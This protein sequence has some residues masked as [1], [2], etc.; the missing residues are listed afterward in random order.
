MKYG[1]N[2]LLWTDT[3]DESSF[4][5][6]E[7]LKEFGYDAVE[8]P[9]FT[10][11][12]R[13]MKKAGKKLD[14]LG[15][16]RTAVTTVSAEENLLSPDAAVRRRGIARR[17]K[18]LDAAAAAGC[19]ALVGPLHS[20][21]GVFSGHGPT[22]DEWKRGVEAMRKIAEYAASVDVMLGLEALNRFECYFINCAEQL[23]RFVADV[24]HPY[25]G[26]M[27]DTFHAHIEEKSPK[28]AI[29]RLADHLVHVHISENDRSTPGTGQVAWKKTF[30]ALASVGY[31][32][33]MV[34]EA[35]GDQLEK[36]TAATK[37][38]RP[39]FDTQ[40]RLAKDGLAFMKKQIGKRY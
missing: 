32:G 28:K 33:L 34:I 7:Q 22:E 14:E 4:A 1:M 19:R 21:I 39:M 29:E 18:T 27:Y 24:G 6:F 17:K 15:L 20:A 3:V 2:L 11:D 26:A 13:M 10:A 8:L 5:L 23:A 31:D 36:I 30:D 38:W 25:C 9:L 35:F 16:L 37:I 40:E 12:L